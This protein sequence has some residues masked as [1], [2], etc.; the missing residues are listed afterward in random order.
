MPRSLVKDFHRRG[1]RPFWALFLF[2]LLSLP[3][4]A[5]APPSADT[6]VSSAAPRIN[7][8]VQESE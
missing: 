4:L 3:M 8:S 5:Q 7:G 2:V 6:F 1:G